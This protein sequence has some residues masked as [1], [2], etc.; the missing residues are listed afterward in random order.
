M[1]RHATR[2]LSVWTKSTKDNPGTL[3]ISAYGRHMLGRNPLTS[4]EEMR[5]N[6]RTKENNPTNEEAEEEEHEDA[7]DI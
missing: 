3:P 1:G 4:I 5:Q 2:Q 6:I 7:N